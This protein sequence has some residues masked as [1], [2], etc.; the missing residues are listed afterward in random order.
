MTVI[1]LSDRG[2]PVGKK[3]ASL[4]SDS[5][6]VVF[7]GN[8]GSLNSI[9]AEAWSKGPIIAVM[10]TQ[11]TVRMIAGLVRDKKSDPAVIS[12]D[13]HGKFVIPLLSGHLGGANTLAR[14]IAKKLGA[15]PVVTT[16][17][18]LMGIH[19][20]DELGQELE[21]S[22]GNH[23]NLPAIMTKILNKENVC[24]FGKEHDVRAIA[25]RYEDTSFTIL[26]MEKY[27][28]GNGMHRIVLTD[29]DI[30]ESTEDLILRPIRNHLGIGFKKDVSID[31][32]KAAT[33][34]GLSAGNI[35]P[36]SIATISTIDI[37]VGSRLVEE[38][39]AD[40]GAKVIYYSKEQ[41]SEA[42]AKSEQSDFVRESVGVGAVSE[43]AAIL[44]S[45]NGKIVLR[46]FVHGGVALSIAKANWP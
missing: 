30:P 31:M 17:S 20:L 27:R 13:E 19:A 5:K 18:D 43:P 8:A 15:E 7:T 23:H 1:T 34:E 10:A 24:L 36:G 4:F 14:Q 37:K 11:I 16:A 25:S 12:V 3:I 32:L 26:P 40:Y 38:L 6:H 2:I 28:P 22:I 33:R 44:S 39:A 35:A 46:K 21:Y 41:L 42:V 9:F 45:G 29:E